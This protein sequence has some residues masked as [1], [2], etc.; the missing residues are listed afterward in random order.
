MGQG[1]WHRALPHSARCHGFGCR[2]SLVGLWAHVPGDGQ[3]RS[4]GVPSASGGGAG[5]GLSWG[6]TRMVLSV[7]VVYKAPSECLIPV[8]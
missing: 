3:Q 4:R 1:T 8:I 5:G 6:L 7:D 2:W